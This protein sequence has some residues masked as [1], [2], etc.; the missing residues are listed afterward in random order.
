MIPLVERAVLQRFRAVVASQLGL[1]Y[2]EDRLEFL[3]DVLRQRMDAVGSACFDAYFEQVTQSHSGEIRALAEQLTVN[4]TYFFRNADSFS[5]FV[6]AVVPECTRA[7]SREKRLRILSAGCAS[8]E[9]PYSLALTLRESFPDL[10]NWD[11]EVVGVDVNLAVLDKAALGR[12]SSWSLRATPEVT[13]QRYFRMEA[14]SF[15]LD[16]EIRKMVKFEERN[17]VDAGSSFWREGEYDIVF[18]RNV[19]MYFTPEQARGVVRRLARALSP[20]GFLFLGH[21]ETLRGLTHEF[22]ICHTHDTFYYRRRSELDS[23]GSTD[24]SLALRGSTASPLP[25]SFAEPTD[26]WVDVIRHASA[27]IAALTDGQSGPPEPLARVP[28]EPK[29][30]AAE[31]STRLEIVLDALRRERFT[32]A[33][34]LIGSLP[35][36]FNRDPDALLLHAILLTNSGRLD[37]S[38]EVCSRL[39]AL[40]DLNAAAHHV[41]A[42]CREHSGDSSGAVEHDQTAIYLDAGFAMPHLHLG[43]IAKRQG[44]R[45]TARRELAQASALLSCEEPSRILLFGGGFSRAAL[46]EFCRAQMASVGG[47]E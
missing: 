46:L 28:D 20:H 11:V 24:E 5:A 45:R 27:R 43:M 44:D 7:R 6:G 19:L 32:D 16:P 25:T 31:P 26:S 21:A 37:A 1:D 41:M 35:S 23:R 17:L 38:E 9:E 15:V 40:D 12:Y 47:A 42:L 29:R 3:A 14:Q 34:R 4:E 36:E 10:A 2:G 13:R 8:G 18:C 33:L 39:L 30:A 22:H